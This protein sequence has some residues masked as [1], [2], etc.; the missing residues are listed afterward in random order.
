MEASPSAEDRFR[1]LI[2][3]GRGV[4]AELD[5]EALLLTVVEAARE[6]TGARYAALGVLD[7]AKEGLERFIHTGID[8]A[9]RRMIGDLPRGPGGSRR[10]DP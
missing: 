4:L 3:V 10:A 7:E 9:T 2:E 6:L 1:R 8:D 5:V